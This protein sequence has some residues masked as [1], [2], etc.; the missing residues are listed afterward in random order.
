MNMEGVDAVL[1]EHQ[2]LVEEET[3]GEFAATG[4]VLHVRV[5]VEDEKVV[6]EVC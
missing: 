3:N 2:K 1:K 5:G 6:T 4:G